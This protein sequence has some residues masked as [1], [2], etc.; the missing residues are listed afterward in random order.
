MK[1]KTAYSKKPRVQ[2]AYV[3]SD[4]N[5]LQG[6]TEQHHKKAV[7]INNIIPLYDKTGLLN[8]VNATQAHYGDF[9]QV[10]EYQQA[11]NT[12]IEAQ[13][14]FE[15]LPSSIRK[16]FGNDPGAFIEFVTD[17]KNSDEMIEMGLQNPP[18][19]PEIINVNIVQDSSKK[20]EE[21]P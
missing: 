5:Q 20:P 7:D 17:P 16:K 14:Q 15:A 8:H 18:S 9:T 2:R 11:L 4:G 1:F 21:N 19:E 3:D 13:H 12:V 10:N 6:R